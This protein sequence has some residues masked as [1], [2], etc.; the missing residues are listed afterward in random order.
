VITTPPHNPKRWFGKG[1]PGVNLD[2][3]VGGLI[4]VEG[5]D[6]SGRSTQIEMLKDWL[7]GHG[8]ATVNVGLRRSNLVSAELDKAKQGNILGHITM[9]LFYVTDF[10][11]QLE[12]RIIPA[13][14]AGFIVLAD[15]YIYTLIARAVV[16]GMDRK[17]V[18]DLL[19]VALV[20]DAVFYLRVSPGNLIERNF[21]KNV[22]LDYWE[23]GM[24]IGLSQDMFE[25]FVKYQRRIQAEF[26]EMQKVYNFEVING[27][28][29]QRAVQ[30][31]LQAKLAHVIGVQ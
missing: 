23:S 19:G 16:R 20:P 9:T 10:V 27:N 17:W 12:N 29:S 7:E 31:E 2:E 13:L 30:L 8:R 1:I 22:T 6:G 18:E 3:L 15:R 11:D 24:D 5:A 14:R 21:K 26:T 4:V 28:R 25:S